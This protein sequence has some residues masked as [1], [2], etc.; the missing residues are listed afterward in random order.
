M[1]LQMLRFRQRA[2]YTLCLILIKI[3]PCNVLGQQKILLQQFEC[4]IPH[5][6]KYFMLEALTVRKYKD[7]IYYFSP[8]G[9]QEYDIKGQQRKI[10]PAEDKRCN[11]SNKIINRKITDIMARIN[12]Q[13]LDSFF[14][15]SPP[16]YFE[17]V[18]VDKLTGKL[19]KKL[20]YKGSD[21]SI[22]YF[23]SNEYPNY[24]FFHNSISSISPYFT[25][26]K[27]KLIFSIFAK[28]SLPS[29][30]QNSTCILKMFDYSV[31]NTKLPVL[32]VTKL[33]WKKYEPNYNHKVC[34]ATGIKLFYF[35]EISFLGNQNQ[36]IVKNISKNQ[37]PPDGG[38]GYCF[39]V[40]T[41]GAR[42]YITPHYSSSQIQV[43]E[44]NTKD[45]W[46]YFSNENDVEGEY[47]NTV[48]SLP[49]MLDS[50]WTKSE[51][52]RWERK[53]SALFAKA[54][55]TNKQ[56]SQIYYSTPQSLLFRVRQLPEANL[57]EK[58]INRLVSGSRLRFL[59]ARY[60]KP[61]TLQILDPEKPGRLIAEIPV[62]PH[63]RI[64]DTEPGGVI[65]A[66]KEVNKKEIIIAKYQ[67][68][69]EGL[70][71]VK[72]EAKE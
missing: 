52:N 43:C 69:L 54:L 25:Y 50:N 66:V 60:N 31:F 62:P 45:C 49:K 70:K 20:Q 61:A 71:E 18:F 11:N 65:W 33:D 57:A 19:V 47:Q 13:V 32:I 14:I 36:R 40:D 21:E 41:L 44:L 10:I 28:D 34:D 5:N 3:I 56:N 17:L 48:L 39:S 7:R 35:N 58:E 29:H 64:L 15:V 37:F 1:I 51:V 30:I 63:F 8:L 38:I 55:L 22:N 67:L 46:D 2:I 53:V 24:K 9:I 27:D 42:I 68:D 23:H 6:E 16:G 59:S 26:C 12:Y 4:F 72:S